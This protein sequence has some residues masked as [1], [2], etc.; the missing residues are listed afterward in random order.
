VKAWLVLALAGC[1]SPHA[2]VV[3]A[4][5]SAAPDAALDTT[6]SGRLAMFVAQ[7]QVGR[8]I[9]SCDDGASWVGKHSWDIDGDPLM[10]SRVQDATCGQTTCSYEIGG[11]CVDIQCCDD[12]PDVPEGV[13]FGADAIVGAWGHG[14][15]G[16]IRTSHDGIAWS[17][18]EIS[19]AYS[20]A[21][22]GG[23]FVAA[24]NPQTSWSNDGIIWTKGGDAKFATMGSPVR[25][26]GYGDSLGGRFVAVSAG[27]GLRDILV[28]S[29]GGVSWWRPSTIPDSCALGVGAGGGGIL[30]F[31]GILLIV[32]S[33]GIACRSTDGGVTWAVYPTGVTQV[34]SQL[35]WTGHEL[36]F[37]SQNMM[38]HSSDGITWDATPMVT[39]T[40]IGPVA[41]S[42]SGTYVAIRYIFDSYARQY[43]LRS[44]DG[45]TWEQ[46]PVAA[47][48]QSHPI[49]HIAFGYADQSALCTGR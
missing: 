49:F 19:Y 26:I 7:G 8:T 18:E 20:V 48:V 43:F 42:D 12:T 4:D 24:G 45:L 46:L 32:D 16:A 44:T 27:G 33:N 28:S 38:M 15:P 37:W 3:A 39:Q 5:T 35:V 31:N 29:D 14:K 10:C 11:Q 1:S 36:A 2:A 30:G 13:A 22:G 23:R 17:T 40:A 9:V 21:S 47:T 34:P 25:A 6:P 41:V